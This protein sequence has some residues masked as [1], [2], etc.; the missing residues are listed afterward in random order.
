MKN[1]VADRSCTNLKVS[2]GNA[3]SNKRKS[4]GNLHFLSSKKK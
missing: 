2:N 3:V 1:K 4:A